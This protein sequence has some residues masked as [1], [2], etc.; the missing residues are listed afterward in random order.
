[1]AVPL[2]DA[3][4][5]LILFRKGSRGA[6]VSPEF[7]TLRNELLSFPDLALVIIDPLQAF[8]A[9]DL[10][11]DVAAAQFVCSQLAQLSADT[12][13]TILLTHHMRKGSKDVAKPS[14]ARDAVRGSTAIVDGVRTVLAMWTPPE[15]EA[16]KACAALNFEFSPHQ[17]PIVHAAVV[18]SNWPADRRIRILHRSRTGLL[19]DQTDAVKTKNPNREKMM[20]VL[21]AAI[22]KAAHDGRPYTRTGQSGLYARR[23]E[24][25][26][27]LQ[28][29]GRNKLEEMGQQLLDSGALCQC[30]ATGSKI[31]K[32][33]DTPDGP[34]AK[35]EGE[36][37]MGAQPRVR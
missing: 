4:G 15:T 17:N 11:A 36:F 13:A 32:W 23:S 27:E 30:M 8:V 12:G 28:N 14:E 24:L 6:E 33:L 25:P 3:G 37:A 10:N 16:R 35:G 26:L 29:T 22:S 21:V 20:S 19:I 7:E 18:K 31:T 2:P 5:P 34:F 9:L 1:M